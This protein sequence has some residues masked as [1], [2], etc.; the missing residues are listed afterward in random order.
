MNALLAGM[1]VFAL[2]C[3]IVGH[4]LWAWGIWQD[5]LEKKK[6]AQ[7]SVTIETVCDACGHSMTQTGA[8]SFRKKYLCGSCLKKIVSSLKEEGNQ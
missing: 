4:A 3:I 2:G 6:R 1:V 7:N 8:Y 5:K